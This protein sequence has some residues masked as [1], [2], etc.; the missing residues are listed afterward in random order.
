MC[1]QVSES[2]RRQRGNKDNEF[3]VF[4]EHHG[5]VYPGIYGRYR[6]RQVVPA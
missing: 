2:Q 3:L 4:A 6:V 5:R 1:L